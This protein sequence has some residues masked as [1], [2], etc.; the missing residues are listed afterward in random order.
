MRK[1][2]VLI[3]YDIS[4]DRRRRKCVKLLNSYGNRVQYSAF[5]A[6]MDDCKYHKLLKTMKKMETETDNI[7]VY[8]LS[9]CVEVHRFGVGKKKLILE[10]EIFI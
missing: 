3:I 5:E 1:N 6:E 2:K 10:D 9:G 4:D 8:K 7:R